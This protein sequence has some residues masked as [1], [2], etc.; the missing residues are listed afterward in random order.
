MKLKYKQEN[1]KK[2][3]KNI[4]QICKFYDNEIFVK[5]GRVILKYHVGSI[6]MIYCPRQYMSY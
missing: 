2:I 1:K 6:L 5:T 3:K 4:I